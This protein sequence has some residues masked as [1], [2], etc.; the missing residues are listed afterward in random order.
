ME[1]VAVY[2]QAQ[3]YVQRHVDP[4]QISMYSLHL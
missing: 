3:P 1:I 4:E 2:R